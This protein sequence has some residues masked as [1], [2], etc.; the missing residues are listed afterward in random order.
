MLTPREIILRQRDKIYNIKLSF[1]TQGFIL[2][3]IT[4]FFSWIVYSSVFYVQFDNLIALKDKKISALTDNLLVAKEDQR[5][6]GQLEKHYEKTMSA[7][8]EN[9]EINLKTIENTIK[10]AGL[11]ANQ[12]VGRSIRDIPSGPLLRIGDDRFIP[13]LR[14]LVETVRKASDGETCLFIQIIDFLRINRRPT[15]EK[16][17][18]R[19]LEITDELV[20]FGGSA[21]FG[22]DRSLGQEAEHMMLLHRAWTY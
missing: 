13:G 3:F 7:F 20:E 12:L 8:L 2:S 22:R 5:K 1:V 10:I 6:L 21:H 4:I 16:Y 9:T 15:V 18:S 11:D 14:E 19:Y 17:F